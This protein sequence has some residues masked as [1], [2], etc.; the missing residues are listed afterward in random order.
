MGTF[1][2]Y[3]GTIFLTFYFR[4]HYW[5]LWSLYSE[6]VGV[7]LESLNSPHC[8][9]H[10]KNSAGI[11][12]NLEDCHTSFQHFLTTHCLHE[13]PNL[14][15]TPSYMSSPILHTSLPALRY[16]PAPLSSLSAF[17]CPLVS[18]WLNRSLCASCAELKFYCFFFFS[19]KEEFQ[20][21]KDTI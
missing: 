5:K 1:V 20:V 6:A 2:I 15:H 21:T 18:A 19:K 17:H 14:P 10:S 9:R 8:R 7:V 11:A 13:T 3:L 12:L 4:Y 16:T